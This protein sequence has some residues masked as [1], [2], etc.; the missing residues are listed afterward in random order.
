M[1]AARFPARRPRP[2]VRAAALRPD[3]SEAQQ[4]GAN[5]PPRAAAPPSARPAPTRPFFFNCRELRGPS[6]PGADF[7]CCEQSALLGKHSARCSLALVK[8]HSLLR[9]SAL[10]AARFWK[11]KMRAR[12][13]KAT[14]GL[15]LATALAFFSQPVDAGLV[16]PHITFSYFNT[17]A[18]WTASEPVS[19]ELLSSNNGACS[20][21]A[22]RVFRAAL[23]LSPLTSLF[24]LSSLLLLFSHPPL[25]DRVVGDGFSVLWETAT[26][27][28][29]VSGERSGVYHLRAVRN[30]CGTATWCVDTAIWV[31][32]SDGQYGAALFG[33]VATGV[34]AILLAVSRLRPPAESEM[35]R[36]RRLASAVGKAE[37]AYGTAEDVPLL[38]RTPA[39]AAPRRFVPLISGGSRGL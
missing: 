19:W 20:T 12:T 30:G 5:G 39:A 15:A 14:F 7:A 16:T 23:S 26:H 11:E 4:V 1:S 3:R 34:C 36:R 28:Q 24:C 27:I 6:S 35:E 33:V 22:V 13:S 9:F 17:T 18:N 31:V 29:M 10:F 38:S 32:V 2:R 25:A 21:G 37:P 8:P